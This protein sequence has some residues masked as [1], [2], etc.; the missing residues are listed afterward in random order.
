MVTEVLDHLTTAHPEHAW[1]RRTIMTAGDHDRT[2]S[3]RDL[4]S[5]GPGVFAGAVERALLAGEIDVAVHSLKDLPTTPT[6]GTA[7]AAVP[8]RHDA[9]AALCGT[10]L[11]ALASGGRVG[12]S[13]PRRVGQLHQACPAAVAVPIR[14]N[15][16]PRLRQMREKGLSGVVL[17]AAG[18]HRLGMNGSIT[19][20]LDPARWPPS[21]AQGAIAVQ[22][23]SGDTALARVV[24]ALHDEESAATTRA[25]RALL[26]VLG[27]GCHVPVGAHA[28]VREGRLHLIGQA[29]SPDGRTVIRAE[30][31][32]AI[33][34]A[35]VVGENVARRLLDDGVG[36]ILATCT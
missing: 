33:T 11:R 26:R 20:Y 19:E 6:P 7:V 34:E 21:P 13:A 31:S 25:E 4:S 24:A 10:T 15:V 29:T 5:S 16:P 36:D 22:V 27:G 9:R 1:V 35:D 8:R 28:T 30:L 12:T 2:S 18:L 23:R 32:G 3:L 14:G 17:A